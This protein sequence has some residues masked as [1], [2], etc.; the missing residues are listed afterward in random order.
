[1]AC[2]PET[3]RL[4]E[5]MSE[6]EKKPSEVLFEQNE[7]ICIKDCYFRIDGIRNNGLDLTSIPKE[8]GIAYFRMKLRG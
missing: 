2:D 7:V 1:M 6:L 4:R 3:G 5:I 8:Q